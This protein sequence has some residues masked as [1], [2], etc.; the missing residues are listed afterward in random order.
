M[1]TVVVT[2]MMIMRIMMMTVMMM[3]LM[4]AAVVV[5][6]VVVEVILSKSPLALSGRCWSKLTAPG[7]PAWLQTCLAMSPN[8]AHGFEA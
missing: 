6:L 3:R 1:M 5:I 7:V 4:I 8:T 2:I